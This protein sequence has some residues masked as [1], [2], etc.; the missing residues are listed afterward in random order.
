MSRTFKEDLEKSWT[1]NAAGWTHAVREGRIE[2]R[3]VATDSAIIEAVQACTPRRAI[4]VGCG[5]G[6]LVRAL[7][8]H[9]IEVVGVDASAPLIEAARAEGNGVFYLHSY[10]ELAATPA[11]PGTGFDAVVFNFALLDEEI[12]PILQAVKHVLSPN[13]TLFI[14]TVHPWT[15]QGEAPYRDAWRTETFNGFGAGF[16]EPM[17][18]FYRTLSSWVSLLSRS[19]YRINN[20]QEP[21]HPDT[22]KPLSLLFVCTPE[23]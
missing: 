22:G 16:P 9:G 13:G 3:R 18:W 11:L 1:A 5:E 7:G 17:P 12:G 2:S 14:Q 15:A 4:D 20:L 21:L 23:I 10:A 19:G 6:W 8:K